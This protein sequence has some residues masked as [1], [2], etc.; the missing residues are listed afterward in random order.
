MLGVV[1][2]DHHRN[3]SGDI[4][5]EYF[6]D[7][8]ADDIITELACVRSLSVI[9]RNSSFAYKGHAVD[10]RKVAR[11]LGVRYILEG[12]VRRGADRLR[13]TAQLVDAETGNHLWA[14]R[15][16]KPVADLFEMQDEIV[17]RLA[18]QLGTELISAEARRGQQ[19]A[20]PD[21]M[22]LYFQGMEWLNRG[23]NLENMNH[24]RGFFERAL[25]LDPGNV[26]ALLGVGR[27]DFEV[28]GAFLSDDRPARL[29]SAEATMGKVLSLRPNDARA[30]EILGRAQV[31]TKRTAQGIAEFERA[32][33]LDPNLAAAH[34][35]IGLAKIF[36]G[37]AEETEAHVTDALRLSPRDSSAWN[38]L[39]FAGGAKLCLGADEEAVPRLRR[40]IEINRTFPLAHF[41]LAAALANL[42]KLDEAQAETRVGLTL[43]PTFTI[44]RF[45][46]GQESDNPI[47]LAGKERIFEGMR[48]AGVPQG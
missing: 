24:A 37:R 20:N 44:Q 39:Q 26:D 3:M 40:S 25:A 34:G 12:S 29:A 43:D 38:W 42:G 16:D 33:A 35:D 19:A 18:N 22:D 46:A 32:L 30:H 21:S 47:F 10:V 7:G 17:A 4:E 9:A 36:I 31:Q 5:Q 27:A 23:I 14:D 8:V 28:G 11:E 48:K 2:A 41:F 1:G 13:V 6:A 45:R 15:F